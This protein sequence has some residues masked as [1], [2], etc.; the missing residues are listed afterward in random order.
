MFLEYLVQLTGTMR[1]K[2]DLTSGSAC[3]QVKDVVLF[4]TRGRFNWTCHNNHSCKVGRGDFLSS[5][6]RAIKMD[7]AQRVSR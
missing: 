5:P 1:W 6:S 4:E 7:G 2:I 3:E